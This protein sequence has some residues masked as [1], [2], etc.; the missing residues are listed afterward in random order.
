M[1]ERRTA[2]PAL[3]RTA[4]CTCARTHVPQRALFGP[5]SDRRLAQLEVGPLP[6]PRFVPAVVQIEEDRRRHDGNHHPL[7]HGKSAPLLV[8][9]RRNA[10][11]RF[12]SVGGAAAEDDGM[13]DLHQC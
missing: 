7:P 12:E 5:R 2:D 1:D 13:G 4:L 6:H 10:A 3:E 11:G 9:P 8:Q